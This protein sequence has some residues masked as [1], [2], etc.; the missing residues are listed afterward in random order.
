[1]TDSDFKPLEPIG[2]FFDRR[3]EG[4]EEHQ[5]KYVD[6]GA[7]LYALTASLLPDRPRARL[8]DL[9]SG[10]GM[11]LDAYLPAHPDASVLGIDL[12]EK[13]TEDFRRKYVEYDAQVI[14]GSYFDVP[15]GESLYDAAV[16]V[17]SLHHFTKEQKIPLYRKLKAALKPAGYFV[18]TD[19]LAPDEDFEAGRFAELERMKALSGI[20]DDG[21]Y[22]FDTPLTLEHESEALKAGG[23]T[24][25]GVRARWGNSFSIV[26]K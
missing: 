23:F 21:F 10:S 22:H 12:S 4:Y 6:G 8:L 17:M 3:A 13:L 7:E 18:L 16:S 19:Y 11:E 9:G 25:I 20:R 2:L 1:M 15:F 24:E 5:R 14:L 26:A